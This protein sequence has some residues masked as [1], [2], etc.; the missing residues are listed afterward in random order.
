LSR[1]A[2]VVASAEVAGDAVLRSSVEEE[3]DLSGGGRGSSAACSCGA[4]LESKGSTK[5]GGVEVLWAQRLGG[6]EDG[7]EVK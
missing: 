4:W 1:R 3:V 6:R 2:A 7:D 5:N